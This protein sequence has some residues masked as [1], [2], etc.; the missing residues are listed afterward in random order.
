MIRTLY[1]FCLLVCL[2]STVTPASAQ[3]RFEKGSWETIKAKA[4]AEKK[5]IFVDVYATWCSPC[6]VLDRQVFSTKEAGE[7]MNPFFIS[8]KV[9]AEAGGRPLALQYAVKAYPTGL[10]LDH[11]GKV[12]HQFVGF[13]PVQAFIAEADRAFR[14]TENGLVYSLYEEAFQQ[15]RRDSELLLIYFKFRRVYNLPTHELLEQVLA[16]TPADSLQ[17]PNW[18]KFIAQ[19]T[20]WAR[21]KG[22]EWL[23]TQKEVPN[24]KNRLEFIISN[25]VRQAQETKD[26]DLFRQTLAY[27]DEIVEPAAARELK[28]RYEIGFYTETKNIDQLTRS[29][30]RY[31]EEE[32]RPH[33]TEETRQNDPEAYTK[34][35]DQLTSLCWTYVNHIK[36]DNLS[37]ICD[38]MADMIRKEQNP[39]LLNQYASLLYKQGNKQEAIEAQ[40]Q[41]V[42]LA[43]NLSPEELKDFENTLKQMKRNKL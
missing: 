41:A 17:V 4:K 23:L 2:V 42:A 29:A 34:A 37:R 28:T 35:Q 7:K 3:I 39:H 32:V 1:L 36:K 15:K 30:E 19:N 40:T 8:Y 5:L 26:H 12:V 9:D 10:F 13:R 18:Q 24:I 11:E 33:L 38:C 43:Q 22:F 6:K 14:T 16:E 27:L 21:G 20:E 25:T 31:L